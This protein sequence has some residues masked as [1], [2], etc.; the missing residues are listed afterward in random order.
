MVMGMQRGRLSD[1]EQGNGRPRSCSKRKSPNEAQK[2]GRSAEGER[3]LS[4]MPER[5]VTSLAAL[6]IALAPKLL[7]LAETDDADPE[8]DEEAEVSCV[9]NREAP[10]RETQVATV[11]DALAAQPCRSG[12]ESEEWARPSGGVR[13][14]GRRGGRLDGGG[15]SDSLHAREQ[16]RR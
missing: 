5:L 9:G 2:P 7:K 6:G 15:R 1:H 16:P 8:V 3:G 10:V 13:S 14:S 4:Q 12:V 11:D